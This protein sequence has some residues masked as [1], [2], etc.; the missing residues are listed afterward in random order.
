[1]LHSVHINTWAKRLVQTLSLGSFDDFL[2]GKVNSPRML[3][4]KQ[5]RSYPDFVG[6]LDCQE[7]GGFH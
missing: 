4:M 5:S 7:S 6:D 3:S 2:Y 1:M